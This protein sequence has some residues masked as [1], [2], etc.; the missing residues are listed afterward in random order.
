MKEIRGKLINAQK[1]KFAII[2]GR[3]NEIITKSL[4]EGAL[5]AFDQYGVDSKNLTVIW[6]PGSFEIPVVAKK[7]ASSSKFDAVVCLGAVIRGA[8]SHYDYVCSQAA[9]GIAKASYESGIPVIFSVL[10]T[11]TVEQA[12]DRAGAKCGNKGFEGAQCA[13]EM[14]DLLNQI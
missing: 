12:M 11:E 5:Q 2:C 13:I 4:L 14:A 9:A 10:T 1:M 7:L 8:T 3:F 6:V